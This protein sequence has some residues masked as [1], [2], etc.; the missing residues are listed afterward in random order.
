MLRSRGSMTGGATQRRAEPVKSPRSSRR[1]LASASSRTPRTPSAA[2]IPESGTRESLAIPSARGRCAGSRGRSSCRSRAG[3]SRSGRRTC[4]VAGAHENLT[5]AESSVG[6]SR[7]RRPAEEFG[8]ASIGELRDE[9]VWA[10]VVRGVLRA[11]HGVAA[12]SCKLLGGGQV[13]LEGHGR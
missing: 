7:R 6:T 11:S 3:S 5:I 9:S 13:E 8:E 2:C 1:F 12:S 4:D 10:G